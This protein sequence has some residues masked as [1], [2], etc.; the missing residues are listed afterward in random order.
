MCGEFEN[1]VG[2][3][4]HDRL[5]ELRSA[6][7]SCRY[8]NSRL[9]FRGP[10]RNLSGRYNAFIGGKETFGKYLDHPYPAL[11]EAALGKTCVNFGVVNAGVDVFVNDPTIMAACATADITVIQMMGAHN[12]SNRFYKVHPRRNDRFLSGSPLM[13]ALY[14]DMDFSEYNF[15]RHLLGAL[16]ERSP[17]RFEIIR[18]ELQ[19]AWLARMKTLLD[20]IGQLVVLLWLS[21]QPLDDQPWT[22][23]PEPFKTEPM[24]V[25]R[26]MVE[27][28]RDKVLDVVVAQTSAEA[29][30]RGTDGMSF[31]QGEA[32]IA[33][34][35]PGVGAHEEAAL[36]LAGAIGR[37]TK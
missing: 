37:H 28:L 3:M 22:A 6:I 21:D 2:T 14:P 13:A 27:Q 4:K 26:T 7:P 16:F 9:F 35:L 32:S 5:V 30:Q 17:E 1:L 12:L 33:S 15:T 34:E 8:G 23:R 18:T 11:V 19:M 10:K 24:L 25:S 29:L 31:P 20:K 36:L